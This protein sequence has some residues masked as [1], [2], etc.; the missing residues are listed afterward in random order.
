MVPDQTPPRSPDAPARDPVWSLAED[1]VGRGEPVA[2]ME[3]AYERA[4]GDAAAIP[5]WHVPANPSLIAWLDERTVGNHARALVV[6]CG[7]G[8]DAEMMAAR[9]YRVTAFDVSETAV[10]WAQRR[11][12]SSSVD[13]VVADV[14]APPA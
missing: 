14:L 1:S 13:Y 8:D 3:Q 2:G 6:G 9:G 10:E 11:F 7:L 5:G 12:S 4:G